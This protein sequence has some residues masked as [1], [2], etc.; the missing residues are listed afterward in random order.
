MGIC[1]LLQLY[2][3]LWNFCDGY[4]NILTRNTNT[5]FYLVLPWFTWT[6]F[7]LSNSQI[8]TSYLREKKPTTTYLIHVFDFQSLDLGLL[9]LVL[10]ELTALTQWWLGKAKAL[11]SQ[12]LMGR[13]LDGDVVSRICILEMLWGILYTP[14]PAWASPHPHPSV[15]KLPIQYSR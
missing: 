3:P 7:F 13:L 6:W 15:M 12:W 5:V 8:W 11:T 14:L 2:Y 4:F 1:V 9:V 10:G